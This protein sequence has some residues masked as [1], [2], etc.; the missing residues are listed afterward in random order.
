MIL[1]AGVTLL[2]E[3]KVRH[4]ILTTLPGLVAIAG[5][6]LVLFLTRT[7]QNSDFLPLTMGNV[8][9]HADRIGTILHAVVSELGST[10]DWSILW[11]AFPI[12]V[13]LLAIRG[14]R[15]LC[16]QLGGLIILPLCLYAG[17]YMLSSWNPYQAHLLLSLPRLISHLSLVALMTMGIAMPLNAGHHV[18]AAD[19]DVGAGDEGG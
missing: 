13:F 14:N 16:L 8:T 2:S 7:P 3:R 12:S 10:D 15:T 19:R 4:A 6:R 5:C 1:V 18:A 11:V 17:V 9:G